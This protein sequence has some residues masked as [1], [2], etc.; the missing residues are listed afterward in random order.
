MI[1]AIV[2]FMCLS[3]EYMYISQVKSL[4]DDK[5]PQTMMW[6]GMLHVFGKGSTLLFV[7]DPYAIPFAVAGH[8]TGTFIAMWMK[9]RRK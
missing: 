5:I 1:Y 9:R 8:V 7:F 2:Y 6:T 4:V 3:I